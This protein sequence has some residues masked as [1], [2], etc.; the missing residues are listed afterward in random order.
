[1]KKN[2]LDILI[3][4]FDR[5]ESLT[6]GEALDR[7]GIYALSQRCGELKRKRG[8]VVQKWWEKLPSGK[9]IRRWGKTLPV[10]YS[11]TIAPAMPRVVGLCE[12]A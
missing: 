4:A 6:V 11:D 3:E 8:Y 5:G 12:A 1:M 2:Q 9:H 10:V 7:Y